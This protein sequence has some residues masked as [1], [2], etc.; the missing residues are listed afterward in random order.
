[1]II[2]GISA[3]YHDAAACLV[4]DGE[5]IAAAQQER[6]S[7]KKHDLNMP[8]DAIAFCLGEG[9]ISAQNIDYIVYYDNPLLTL[10]RY[11]KNILAAGKGA[12]DVI[13]RSYHSMFS[14][15]LWVHNVINNILDTKAKVLVCE[16]HISHAA[17]AFYPSPFKEAVVI[18]I[19][20]VGEWDTTTIGLGKDKALTIKE[21]IKF[22]HSLGLLY[23]AFTYFCG[24]KVNSG[25]YKF[26]GLAP[27]G[28][29][30]YETLI[31][32]K[33]VDIKEDGSYRLNLEYFDFQFGRAMTN[34]KFGQLFG[35]KRREP[36]SKITKREMNI[37][38]SAQKVIEDIIL[39]IVFHAKKM[40]GQDIPN[41][42]LAGGVALNCVANGRIKD[43]GIFENIWIQP[44]A[45]DAGGCLGAALYA[46]Y[47]YTDVKRKVESDDSQKGSYLGPSYSNS[48][49]EEFLESRALQYHKYTDEMLFDKIADDLSNSMVI[50][51]FH[52]KMEFGPRALGNRSIIADPRSEM[53]QSKLNLKI[54][55]RESFRPFAPSVLEEDAGEYFELEGESPYMLLVENVREDRRIVSNVQADLKKYHDDMLEIVKKRRS[56]ISAVT[57]VDYSARIQTVSEKR[58]QYFYNVLKAFKKKT[59][60][61]VLVNTSFNVRGEP[62]VCTPMDAY[63][64]FMR[65][66]MDALV[67]GNYILYK[68]EQP[69]WNEQENWRQIYELD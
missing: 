36:E 11:M 51:L 54:K 19:D 59:G 5:I 53:M 63:K 6:F 8:I 46:T 40:Y 49:I 67:L 65:T 26:M 18:T 52:G 24:F 34:E 44:A 60:C 39:K 45:G 48:F 10:D 62:I 29:P 43:S 28:E 4:I 9:K 30:V 17:S 61:S 37:A 38:A 12:K 66:D 3:L 47:K 41:L 20:G 22:P 31:R 50:G 55:Y 58:N 14:Q 16:H 69:E 23:S 42:V 15:K 7:R 33:I 2:L 32:E 27:Y 13:E 1:M 57:H 21:E 64:C 68:G 56:D 25:D 35:G